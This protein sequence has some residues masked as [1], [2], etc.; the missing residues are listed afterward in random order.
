M[1]NAWKKFDQDLS[2]SEMLKHV[3]SEGYL[4]Y[5][6]DETGNNFETDL[7]PAKT[8]QEIYG[9]LSDIVHGKICSF[10]SSIPDKFK[11]VKSEWL[12]FLDLANRVL[13]IL[14]DGYLSRYS[15][16]GKIIKIVPQSKMILE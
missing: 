15:L 9:N 16:K 8:C 13:K 6:S 1:A 5:V 14:I 4:S 11:F 2:F 7:F 10:E 12:D 3:N